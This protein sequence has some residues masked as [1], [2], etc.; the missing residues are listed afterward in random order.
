MTKKL[1]SRKAKWVTTGEHYLNLE[2]TAEKDDAI[3][4]CLADRNGELLLDIISTMDIM[5]RAAAEA[6]AILQPGQKPELEPPEQ[7]EQ[8]DAIDG[9]LQSLMASLGAANDESSIR[10]DLQIDAPTDSSIIDALKNVMQKRKQMDEGGI[11]E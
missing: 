1:A 7:A 3:R 2:S 9:M 4:K 11:G 8:E 6:T 5:R 10:D